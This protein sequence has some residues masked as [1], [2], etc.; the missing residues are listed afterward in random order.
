MDAFEITCCIAF[1]IAL[2]FVVW[3]DAVTFARAKRRREEEK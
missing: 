1:P 2:A 3:A